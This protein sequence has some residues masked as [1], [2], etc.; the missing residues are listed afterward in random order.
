MPQDQ[1][2]FVTSVF[3]SAITW[4][5]R[6]VF[7][8]SMLL[9]MS[10][11]L[12]IVVA[13]GFQAYFWPDGES[14]V[15]LQRAFSLIVVDAIGAT[16]G[17]TAFSPGALTVRLSDFV[18]NITFVWTDLERV[19]FLTRAGQ[20]PDGPD[21]ALFRF[22]ATHTDKVETTMW[23]TRIYGA[24]LA[25]LLTSIPLFAVA[26]SVATVDGLVLRYIRREGGGRESS[27]MYH[28]AKYLSVMLLGSVL[29]AVLLLP[30]SYAPSWVLPVLALCVGVLARTQWTYYK[31]YL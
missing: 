27:F 13:L 18:Y 8:I 7:W 22:V 9:L 10:W 17:V 1:S 25:L 5:F 30:L 21:V 28:R 4:P 15:R 12:A 14:L 16:D 23:A 26:Y 20:V 11:M 3:F 2:S 31:K 19:Y 6:W 24:K 29:L